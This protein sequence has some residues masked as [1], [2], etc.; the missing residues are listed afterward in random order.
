M[1]KRFISLF[2]CLAL[3]AACLPMDARATTEDPDTFIKNHI[4]QDMTLEEKLEIICGYVAS[5]DYSDTVDTAQRMLVTGSGNDVAGSELLLMLCEKLGIS[6]KLRDSSMDGM[7]TSVNVLVTEGTTYYQLET[8]FREMAPRPYLITPRTSLFSYSFVSG[9]IRVNRYDGQLAPGASLTVPASIDGYS[10]VAIGDCFL[11]ANE[12]VAEVVLPNSLRSIGDDAFNGCSSLTALNIPAAT[13][14]LG[15]RVFAGCDKLSGLTC[16]PGGSFVLID[17]VLYTADMTQLVAA[18]TARNI[19]PADTISRI[20]PYAFMGS[21]TLE[22]I[23]IPAGVKSIGEGAFADCLALELISFQGDQPL[24]EDFLFV[25][26]NANAFAAWTGNDSAISWHRHT[27]AASVAAWMDGSGGLSSLSVTTAA[28][29]GSCTTVLPVVFDRA[30]SP[31]DAFP[32]QVSVPAGSRVTLR[33]L[34]EEP[35]NGSVILL[36][37]A[38]GSYAPIVDTVLTEDSVLV[39][40]TGSCTLKVID[41]SRN[42]PDVGPT[43]WAKAEIDYLSARGIISGKLDG[44]F[45]HGETITRKTLALILWRMAGSPTVP[46]DTRLTDVN[47]SDRYTQAICWAEDAG[48]I[49]GY[50]DQTFRGD[51]PLTRQHFAVM[52]YR[53]ANYTGQS[54]AQENQRELREFS[55]HAS[56]YGWAQ[57]AALWALRRGL[58]NGR[59]NGTFDPQGNTSRAQL[60]VILT[61]YLK[62]LN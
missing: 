7:G 31:E 58:I 60:A 42:F 57:S 49:T 19:F 55:D 16:A 54:P 50:N 18:P 41:G 4:R 26:V 24:M 23:L 1:M 36:R 2:L 45:G 34:L 5:F 30:A 37:Q 17:H 40:V 13:K 52:L 9:G 21:G 48:I 10:V 44:T 61:R 35:G 62:K 38:D 15:A 11:A 14:T 32:I 43:H 59:A 20:V 28:V 51:A 8:G 25:G 56:V 47:L 53:Y 22:S 27:P 3:L 39:T 6:A 12:N 29:D 33:F 46:V